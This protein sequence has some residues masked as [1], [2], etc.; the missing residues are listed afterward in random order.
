MAGG[1]L[2]LI[3]SSLPLSSFH[4]VY[5]WEEFRDLGQ[6]LDRGKETD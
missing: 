5:T 3:S 1:A 2:A 4:A 6:R